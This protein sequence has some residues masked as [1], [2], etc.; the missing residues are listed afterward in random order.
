MILTIDIGNSVNKY[1]LFDKNNLIQS[2]VWEKE[3]ELPTA[4]IIIS[5]SV[6]KSS[7]ESEV[8]SIL[9]FF[10][11]GQFLDMPVHYS[12][13]LGADRLA[14]GYSVFKAYKR[15]CLCIDSGSFTTVDLITENGFEG[16]YILPGIELINNSY[17]NGELLNEANITTY[18]NDLPHTTEDA[19]NQGATLTVLEP[20]K[21][22]VKNFKEVNIVFTGGNGEFLSSYFSDSTFDRDLVHK[23]LN[24]IGQRTHQ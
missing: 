23:G 21:A 8:I 13:T 24:L 4:D 12:K 7:L 17:K 18:L 5:S 15:P 10:K 19:I 22:I 6:K 9:D 14:A 20:I 11:E 1:S 3:V 2:G 16:G